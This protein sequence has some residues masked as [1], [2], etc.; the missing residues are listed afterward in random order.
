MAEKQYDTQKGIGV[1]TREDGTYSPLD[2]DQNGVVD[3]LT[4]GL[5]VLRYLFGLEGDQVTKGALADDATRTAEEVQEYLEWVKAHPESE[6]FKAFDLD[7]SG[8][9]DALTDG[10]ILLRS[11]FDLKVDAAV[12]GAIASPVLGLNEDGSAQFGEPYATAQEIAAN[13]DNALNVLQQI[14]KDEEGNYSVTDSTPEPEPEPEPQTGD[15]DGDGIPDDEDTD[16]DGDG[17]PDDED[18]D[19]DGDGLLDTLEIE[20]QETNNTYDDHKLAERGIDDS[21][22]LDP[23]VFNKDSDGDTVPDGYDFFPDDASKQVDFD[24]DGVDGHADADDSDSRI[25]ESFDDYVLAYPD[26]D[27]DDDGVPNKDDDFPRQDKHSTDTDKDG[28]PDE[29]DPDKDGDGVDNEEDT[30]ELNPDVWNEAQYDIWYEQ[31]DD[32][33]EIGRAH[34]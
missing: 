28:L 21:L 27:Y 25:L 8:D 13:L 31:Q 11:G 6:L 18:D 2:I 26:E 19:D 32:D 30:L 3:A 34:V 23:R 33:G 24:L 16:L 7:N 22:R 12:E 20:D 15:L 4:D 10:L 1:R 5:L 14:P 17:I 9:L 29:R